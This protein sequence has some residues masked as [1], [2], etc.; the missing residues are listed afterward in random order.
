MW[1]KCLSRRKF[2]ENNKILFNFT[3]LCGY[4]FSLGLSTFPY[5]GYIYII[6]IYIYRNIYI[7]IYIYRNIYIYI[8]IH[9]YIYYIYIENVDIN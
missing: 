1:K 8:Y 9:I 2:S 3:L 5:C 6:Y 7:Y 4:V